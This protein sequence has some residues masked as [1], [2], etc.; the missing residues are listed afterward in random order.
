MKYCPSCGK[1][2]SLFETFDSNAAD[3]VCV[4]KHRLYILKKGILTIET[5][6][7]YL[8]LKSGMNSTEDTLK[9]WLQN[10]ALRDHLNDSLAS[11]IL[12][13][14]ENHENEDANVAGYYEYNC[15]PICASPL[16][17]TESDD[18]YISSCE[19]DNNHEFSKRNGIWK[20]GTRPETEPLQFRIPKERFSS[21]LDSWRTNEHLKDFVPYELRDILNHVQGY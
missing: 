20:K 19:C 6:G 11:L 1:L 3:Y 9:E 16:K 17:K 12:H 7:E 14:L 13:V 18:I 4:N 10:P 5:M 15:C 2:L 21:L 8:N